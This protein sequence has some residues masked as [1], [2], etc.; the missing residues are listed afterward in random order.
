MRVALGISETN[1]GRTTEAQQYYHAAIE[2]FD[3]AILYHQYD[4]YAY[5]IRGYTKICLAD[6]EADKGNMEDARNL[7]ESAITDTDTKSAAQLD[8]KNPYAYHTLGVAKAKLD[9]YTAAIEDFDKTVSLKPDFAEAYYNRAVAKK[10]L[11][12]KDAAKADFQKA[13]QLDQ[14]KGK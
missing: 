11:G 5:I 6:F 2:D 4:T 7:Y 10:M 13:A 12:Q 3:E 1:R 8:T 9:D 14:D